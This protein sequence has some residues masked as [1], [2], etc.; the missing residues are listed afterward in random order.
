MVTL[1]MFVQGWEWF[2]DFQTI[3]TS[4][5][6]VPG[7]SRRRWVREKGGGSEAWTRTYFKLE[8]TFTCGEGEM[9]GGWWWCIR[10]ALISFN[11]SPWVI[12]PSFSSYLVSREKNKCSVLLLNQKNTNFEI[13]VISNGIAEWIGVTCVHRGEATES[14]CISWTIFD[15]IGIP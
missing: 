14:R 5:W 15:S 10:R 6:A 8:V 7:A 9:G 3:F 13:I 1:Q 4:K 11:R 12:S 2:I